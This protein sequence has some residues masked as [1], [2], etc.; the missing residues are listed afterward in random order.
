MRVRFILLSIIALLIFSCIFAL[1]TQTETI[2]PFTSDGCSVFP[3]G[4]FEE[5]QLWL[6]CCTEHDYAYWKGGT[7]HERL[8]ADRALRHC[9]AKVE[10]PIVATLMFTGVR[11][12]GSPIFPTPFRWGYGWSYPRWYK[13][14]DEIEKEQIL[15]SNQ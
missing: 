13:A 10:Q 8:E 11:V 5:K 3:D 4:T 15:I 6:S 14:L 12:G 1:Y 2:K 9:V 7:Y